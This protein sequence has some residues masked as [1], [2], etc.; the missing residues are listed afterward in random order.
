MR[1]H[2]LP[3]Y[4]LHKA[5]GQGIVTLNGK[6]H[7]LG[8]YDTPESHSKYHQVIADWLNNGTAAPVVTAMAVVEPRTT[9]HALTVNEIILRFLEYGAAYYS[10]EGRE[11]EQFKLSL[12]PLREVCGP[13]IVS[14]FG[15]KML[16]TV[17]RRMVEL[18]WCRRV[19]NRRIT[20]I[21]TMMK[22]AES[23]ELIPFGTTHALATVRGLRRGELGV[24]ES[25]PIMP[26]QLA[27]VQA[28]LPHC[29]STIAS[30]LQLQFL[31][32]MRSCEVRL[33][34]TGD[35]DRSN[36]LC[37][38]YRPHR[39]KNDWRESGQERVIPLG[40][41]C[42]K[43][44]S[45]WLKPRRPI[46]FIFKPNQEPSPKGKNKPKG[47]PKPACYS[48]NTYAQAVKRACKRAGVSF[49]PYALRHGRKMMIERLESVEGA[50]TVL[51]QK[52]I[53][54]T[55]HYG[56]LDLQH[57]MNIMRKHG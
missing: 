39:H 17:Q 3:S 33:I 12:R 34:R 7:Y 15:P 24:K 37:W 40:P 46:A 18:G 43:L 1:R 25:K 4:R 45:Q 32:G 38:L 9:Q 52:S 36:P 54:S 35:I 31:A 11:L 8:L 19:V 2:R 5:S 10:K 42:M 51:G 14:T 47:K 21:R 20:R 28:V 50:R 16:K 53:Q 26:A 22:W 30:M 55:Q 29:S 44:L 49:R 56:R 23:E 27:E 41:E 48:A 13:M 6:D 57:A